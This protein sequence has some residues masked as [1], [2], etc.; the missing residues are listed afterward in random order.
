[1]LLEIPGHEIPYLT[2]VIDNQNMRRL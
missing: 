2:V 1:V